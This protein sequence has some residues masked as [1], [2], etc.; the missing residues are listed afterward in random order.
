MTRTSVTAPRRRT[1]NPRRWAAAGVI[2]AL[3]LTAGCSSRETQDQTETGAAEAL[4]IVDQRGE[5]VTLDGPA[6]KVAFTVMPAPSIFAAVDRSYDRIVGIN[7]STLVANQGGMFATMFPESAQSTVVAGSDFVPN[8]E[9]MLQLDP[10]VVVQWGDQGTGIT[11]PIESA[12]FPLVG[13]EYGTQEDL[14]SWIT[15]FAQIAGKPERG[16]ELVAWQHAEIAEMRE[17]VAAQTGDRPRAMILSKTGDT[18]S[19]TT[20]EGYDGFQFDLVGADLVTKGFVSDAGQ[21][22]PEQILAWNPEVIM[23]SGFDQSTP[24][25]IYADPRLASV[26]AVQNKRVYKTPLGGYRW[27]VPSAE[28]PLMWQWMHQVLYPGERTGELRDAMRDA[29]DDLF[30][31]SISEEEIDQV[32][33]FELNGDAANYD[34]FRR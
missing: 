12:G 7:Q 19:T 32:L 10:D 4:T 1:P 2:A 22:N 23:L 6:D 31:Y 18:F 30:A 20:A 33:R 8:V 9:T 21:V 27:Q 17:K 28:S 13:L 26:S 25:D 11:E 14:E 34:Q 5:T 29:F 24:A 15:L 16:D 3:A